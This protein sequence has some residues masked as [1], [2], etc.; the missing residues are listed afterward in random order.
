VPCTWDARLG[1]KISDLV[2]IFKVPKVFNVL[3]PTFELIPPPAIYRT[4]NVVLLGA[5]PYESVYKKFEGSKAVSSL[6]IPSGNPNP[7]L[8]ELGIIVSSDAGIVWFT[9]AKVLDRPDPNSKFKVSF[10]EKR[11]TNLLGTRLNRNR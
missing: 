1:F 5:I 7:T 4:V 8:S 9:A 2:V 10:D 6:L 11:V 3:T